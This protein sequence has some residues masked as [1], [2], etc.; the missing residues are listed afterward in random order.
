MIFCLLHVACAAERKTLEAEKPMAFLG[1][2]VSAAVRENR[3]SDFIHWTSS[4]TP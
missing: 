2:L 3:P 1:D 4:P